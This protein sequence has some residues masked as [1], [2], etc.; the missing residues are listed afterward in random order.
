M[1]EFYKYLLTAF[2]AE[3]DDDYIGLWEITGGLVDHW[4]INRRR[5]TVADA[6]KLWKGVSEFVP[7][8]LQKG[9]V[10]VTLKKDGGCDIWP[11]QDPKQVL[12]KI[13]NIYVANARN[14]EWGVWFQKI[15]Q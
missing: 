14:A 15:K 10:A 12:N 7:I 5:A 2:L 4:K 6:D 13:R 9:F 3:G 1:N 8:L 11:E